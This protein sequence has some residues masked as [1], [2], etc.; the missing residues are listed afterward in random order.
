MAAKKL[1]LS[2]RDFFRKSSAFTAAAAFPTSSFVTNEDVEATTNNV[3]TNS[4]PS[5]LKITDIKTGSLYRSILRIETNQGIV[6]Y[7]EGTGPDG[8]LVL[9]LRG[10]LIGENPCSV[11]MLYNKIK[12]YGDHNRTGGTIG[13]RFL[14][15]IAGART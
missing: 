8:S 14:T 15:R 5:D 11:E 13:S 4:S 9:Q 12:R 6:G 1:N 2:R 7:G 3:N 10:D